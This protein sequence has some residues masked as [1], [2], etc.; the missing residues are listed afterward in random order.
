MRIFKSLYAIVLLMGNMLRCQ[1]GFAAVTPT[2]VK[3]TE[4]AGDVKVKVYTLT[5]ESAS[6]T[7]DLSSDFDTLY[8]ADAHLTAGLDAALTIL[9]PSFSGTTVT[10]KQLKADGATDA[11]DWTGASIELSVRGKKG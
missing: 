4:F 8:S 5:P 3:Q 1:A 9:Q 11:D 10:I 7:I 6:D 2:A